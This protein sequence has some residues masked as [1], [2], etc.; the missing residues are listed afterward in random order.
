MKKCYRR[1]LTAMTTEYIGQAGIARALGVT[2]QAISVWRKRHPDFP[3]PDAITDGGFPS[4]LPER[5]DEIKAWAAARK[6][7]EKARSD[8]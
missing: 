1:K 3:A 8:E 2:R 5:L 4:W 7:R 6:Q